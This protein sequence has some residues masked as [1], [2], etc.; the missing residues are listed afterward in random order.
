MLIDMPERGT[1]DRKQV[2]SLDGL[3]PIAR[4]SGQNR[5]KR[6]VRGGRAKWRQAL[7]M[8]AL[9]ATRFKPDMKADHNALVAAGT[10][11]KLAITAVMQKVRHPRERTAESGMAL[12]AEIS[13]ITTDT[14]EPRRASKMR[15]SRTGS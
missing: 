5:G 15:K 3:L 14:L 4:D 13:L 6:H 8:P 10:P 7:Y 2:A 11:P 1:L 12:D 9:V